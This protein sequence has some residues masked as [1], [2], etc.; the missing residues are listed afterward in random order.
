LLNRLGG[1]EVLVAE[2]VGMFMSEG[3]A[4][5]DALQREVM[6]GGAVGIERAA[7]KLKGALLSLAA[8]PASAIAK[9]MEV[10]ARECDVSRVPAMMANLEQQV[11]AV[12]DA[13]TSFS[14]ASSSGPA[15]AVA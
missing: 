1:D 4:M 15:G 13:L 6:G 12:Y 2:V 11:E 9:E 8:G 3:P 7:H 10:A 5:M 14:A